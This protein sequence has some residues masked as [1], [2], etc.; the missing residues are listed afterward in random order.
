MKIASGIVQM[1]DGIDDEFARQVVPSQIGPPQKEKK[2]MADQ[3]NY[4]ANFA[5]IA[6]FAYFANCSNV[7]RN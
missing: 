6:N 5:Y 3:L 7:G 4:F 1:L 2:N